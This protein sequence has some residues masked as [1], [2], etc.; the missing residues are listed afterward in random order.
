MREVLTRV[1]KYWPQY[2]WSNVAAM[3]RN[4]SVPPDTYDLDFTDR[5]V[6]IAG[7]T[8]GI[9][10]LTARKYAAHGARLLTVNRNEEKSRAL[11]AEIR[12]EFGTSC[13]YLLADLSRLDAMHRVGQAL[14]ALPEP[15]DV[16]IHNAGLFLNK[17]A[18]TPDG[19]ETNFAVHYLAPF[20][21]NYLLREKP[22]RDRRGRILFVGSEG[23]R[24]AVWG[25][26]LDDLQWEKRRYGGLQAY[27]AAK[28]AQLLTMHIL[29]EELAASGVTVNAMHPGMVRTNTGHENGRRYRWFNWHALGQ[30]GGGGRAGGHGGRR[31]QG[32]GSVAQ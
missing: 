25:M 32:R 6:V 10:Y 15:I 22:Q 17:R 3:I 2:H 5:L 8:S 20:V 14:V 11:C 7:A 4:M 30:A 31:R 13:D 27:G 26:R 28:T 12:G 9:G 1:R 16:L 29:A 21:I 18:L 19:L 24:F 23:Y